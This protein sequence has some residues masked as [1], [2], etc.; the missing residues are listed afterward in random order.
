MIYLFF[1][2]LFVFGLLIGSFLNVLIFRYNPDGK[3]FS[4]IK[5]SGRSMCRSCGK[6][7]V[8]RE[9]IPLFSFIF[10]KG[11]CRKCKSKISIQYPIVEFLS[12]VFCAGVP[13]FFNWF[14]GINNI[15]FVNFLLPTS[16][17][18]LLFVWILIFFSWIVIFVIDIRHYVIPDEINIFLL[19]CGGL[20]IWFSN[21]NLHIFQ[22]MRISFLRHYALILSPSQNILV[23]HLLGAL[24]GAAFLGLLFLLSRGR[25][26]G[27]GDIKLIF[28]SGLALGWPD[29]GFAS[30]ISFLL[31]GVYAIMLFVLKKKTMKDKIPFGPFLVLGFLITMLFGYETM[32][33]YFSLFNL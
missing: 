27:V 29:I 20:V 5:L 6:T 10:L 11:K 18:L 7:L 15:S 21:L 14:Y 12:G 8:S 26:I 4:L 24:I 23:S 28:V 16:Y 1:A 9:L 22:P 17:Y 13:L 30:G 31:G 2:I 3:L 25:G 19:L 32:N 33:W